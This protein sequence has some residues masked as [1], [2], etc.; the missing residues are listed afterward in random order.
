MDDHFLKK[1]MQESLKETV[2]DFIKQILLF[3][4]KVIPEGDVPEKFPRRIP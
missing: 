4:E 1:F 2:L 3:S